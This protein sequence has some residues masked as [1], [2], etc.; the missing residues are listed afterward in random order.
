MF[1]HAYSLKIC[2]A[3]EILNA[4]CDKREGFLQETMRDFKL[5]ISRLSLSIQGTSPRRSRCR[6]L[7]PVPEPSWLPEAALLRKGLLSKDQEDCESAE[8]NFD[9]FER[10][11]AGLGRVRHKNYLPALAFICHT[12]LQASIQESVVPFWAT[13]F[14]KFDVSTLHSF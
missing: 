4:C 14:D 11:Y 6:Y 1:I 3:I 7:A 9:P 2:K 12:N 5:W 13:S 8:N 10:T